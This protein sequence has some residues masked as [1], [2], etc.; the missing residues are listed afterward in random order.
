MAGL[1]SVAL[2]ASCGGTDTGETETEKETTAAATTE[3]AVDETEAEVETSAQDASG[4]GD[5]SG[6]LVASGSTS[7]QPLMEAL[8]EEFTAL[9]PG[10]TMEV[11]AGGSTTGFKNVDS[12]V[13]EL[14]NLSRNLKDEEKGDDINEHVLATDG[15]GV[16]VNI[17][18]PVKNLTTEQVVGIFTGEITNWSE[19]GGNDGEIV[20]IQREAGSGTRG[21][22]EEI[23]DIEDA[24]K[25]TQDA[26]ETGIVKNTVA[27]NEN[28]IGYISLGSAD[29]TVH[30][31]SV[32]DVEP[33][34]SAVLDGSYKLSR[35][36]LTIT[37]GEE[38][39]LAK[40]FFEYA[41]SED[42]KVVIEEMGFFA[43]AN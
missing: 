6:K 8:A 13:T 39:E 9:N 4:G 3:A 40:A 22:F 26:N 19:V 33:I 36:L 16:C 25:A 27:G 12:G 28:A 31:V 43:P 34:E 2:L 7:V 42:A 21:A 14:G 11:Q 15:I 1:I 20:V 24:V 37:K 10:V 17:D 23:L 5:L 41:A 30:C 18:N 32:D 35:P 38:S 29:E